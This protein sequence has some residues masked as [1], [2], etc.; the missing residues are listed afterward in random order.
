MAKSEEI[1]EYHGEKQRPKKKQIDKNKIKRKNRLLRILEIADQNRYTTEQLK[2]ALLR[3][4]LVLETDE[5]KKL[6][7]L[8][9][10]R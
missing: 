10:K 3:S 2:T 8:W 6:I 1:K 7:E 4:E 9:E 5:Y